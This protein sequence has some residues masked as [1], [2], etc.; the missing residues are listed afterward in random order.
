MNEQRLNSDAERGSRGQCPGVRGHGTQP[1]MRVNCLDLIFAVM[2][3]RTQ[4]S[5]LKVRTK[6]YNLKAKDRTKDSTMKAKARTKEWT[7]FP[8]IYLDVR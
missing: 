8:R 2:L 1:R 6:D 3:T 4:A 5:S 7:N